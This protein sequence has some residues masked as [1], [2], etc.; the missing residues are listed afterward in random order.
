[1]RLWETLWA[2]PFS[3]HFHLFIA[4]AIINKHRV[5]I[6]TECRAFDEALKFMNDLSGK[7]D[8]D[9]ILRRAEMLFEV[10]RHM[11]TITAWERLGLNIET[12]LSKND[13]IPVLQP[14]AVSSNNAVSSPSVSAASNLPGVAEETA[15]AEK[16]TVAATTSI[17][18]SAAAAADKN[19]DPLLNPSP[20]E[21]SASPVA[22]SPS[23]T[24]TTESQSQG[25]G[26]VPRGRSP[27]RPR[28]AG[29]SSVAAQVKPRSLSRSSSGSGSPTRRS[30][31]PNNN[32]SN[33]AAA[34]VEI[35]DESVWRLLE[36]L[37]REK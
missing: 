2:C 26:L 12:G 28:S 36:L 5:Q 35:D 19:Y 33:P 29:G 3:R 4:L 22:P 24:P 18:T 7:I 23:P 13:T 16:E 17:S 11:V 8:L 31:L 10:F 15:M 30:P 20:V 6:M 9:D 34:L 37:E 21:S 25:Q 1:M 32:S 14:V 27:N